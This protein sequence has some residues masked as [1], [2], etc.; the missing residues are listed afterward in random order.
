MAGPVASTP[1][2]MT[3]SE[4]MNAT[5]RRAMERRVPVAGLME[6]TSRCNLR[7]VHCYLGPQEQHWADAS[8]RQELS[9]EKL[10]SIIDELAD[11]GCLYLGI[12]GGDPMVHEHFADVYRRAC[13][14]GIRVTVLC[15]GVLVRDS[16]V[17]LFKEYPPLQVEVSLYGATK[18]T[19]EAVTKVPGSYVKCIAGIH[20]LLDNGIRVQLKT[21]LIK[22]NAHEV[23]EMR[24]MARDLG[25]EFRVD[26]A[27]FPQLADRAKAPLDHRIAPA[28]AVRL[29]MADPRTLEA[30]TERV[31]LQPV[32]SDNLYR[33]GAGV[34][35]FYVD[36]FGYVSPCIM[37]TN[38]RHSLHERSF[39]SLWARELVQI[40]S[41][42]PRAEYGCNSCEMQ[43]A[44]TSCP[45]FNYQENGH[46]DVKSEYV[47]ETTRE[48]WTLIQLER[49]KTKTPP[50]TPSP[51]GWPSPGQ[52]AEGE[53]AEYRAR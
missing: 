11:A 16:I 9:L 22:L 13:E 43:S 19:Y 2:A 47:C 41:T 37:T 39:A 8:R 20:K 12:T 48:R 15:N 45:A 4:W 29:E 21:V 18:A 31:E 42:K 44:C 3:N 34:T 5:T 46:E 36:P 24:Q 51:V 53:R 14:R 10:L 1:E 30:W 6:L 33:C 49:R 32:P 38:H 28:E 52:P 35:G 25:V 50:P 23:H 7:C 40:R 26:S 17:E 27:I